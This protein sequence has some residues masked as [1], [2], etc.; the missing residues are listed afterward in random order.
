MAEPEIEAVA[1]ADG[2]GPVGGETPPS[3]TARKRA[4]R[5]PRAVE[6]YRAIAKVRIPFGPRFIEPGQVFE[7]DSIPFDEERMERVG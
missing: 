4:G 3:A 6:P 7:S 1:A 2:S 5:A